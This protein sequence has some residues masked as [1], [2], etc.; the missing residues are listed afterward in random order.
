MT[1]ARAGGGP[2]SL[3]SSL[4]NYQSK[5]CVMCA[6]TNVVKLKQLH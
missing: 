2:Q 6:T 1:E 4:K 3:W 5:R